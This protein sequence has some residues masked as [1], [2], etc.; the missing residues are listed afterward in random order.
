MPVQTQG[1]RKVSG[2]VGQSVRRAAVT[3]LR[4]E[5]RGYRKLK[6]SW[7]T[8]AGQP[9]C[10]DALSF[11]NAL[12]GRLYEL[13]DI[14]LPTVAPIS[15]GVM[16]TWRSGIYIEVDD[17]S[18]LYGHPGSRTVGGYGEDTTYNVEDGVKAL[19][20]FNDQGML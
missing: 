20:E 14:P 2:Y 18:V 8:Y 1:C 3:A 5:I 7:D 13:P 9:I 12:L 15:K 19:A 16:L 17:E 11:A 6:V 10:D 4:D